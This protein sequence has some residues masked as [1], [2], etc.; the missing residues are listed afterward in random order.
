MAVRCGKCKKRNATGLSSSSALE[1]WP[2]CDQCHAEAVAERPPGVLKKEH[3]DICI[4]PVCKPY[5]GHPHIESAHGFDGACKVGG[6]RC[7]AFRPFNS[8]LYC[9]R[10]DGSH[11]IRC[12]RFPSGNKGGAQ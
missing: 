8:C 10:V 6:C 11:Y 7:P 1:R 3:L 4:Q 9:G 12:P 2:T 5:G